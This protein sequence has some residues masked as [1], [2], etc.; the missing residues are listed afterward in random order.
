MVRIELNVRCI[1][2]GYIYIIVS[3]SSEWEKSFQSKREKVV[4][5]VGT[6]ARY[7]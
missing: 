6:C 1:V 7:E 5:L 3:F 2:T 4:V